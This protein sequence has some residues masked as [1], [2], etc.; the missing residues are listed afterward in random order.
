V[1]AISGGLAEPSSGGKYCR[2][3]TESMIT[4]KN[5]PG[6]IWNYHG[7]QRLTQIGRF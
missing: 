6:I 4:M 1:Q 3:C 2:F 5:K 7:N